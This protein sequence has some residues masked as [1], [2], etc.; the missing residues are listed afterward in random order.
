[1]KENIK[2]RQIKVMS[3]IVGLGVE[4]GSRFQYHSENSQC[5]MSVPLF[6]ELYGYRTDLPTYS[7][8]LASSLEH[9]ILIIS[10]SSFFVFF[11]KLKQDHSPVN[12]IMKAVCFSMAASSSSH[13]RGGLW[14]KLDV[15]VLVSEQICP[16]ATHIMKS[17]P[18]SL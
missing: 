7:T 9:T 16:L 4:G 8:P 1:M 3:W 11:F 18:F 14:Q 13:C 12:G 5:G 15:P 17:S 2:S 10:I 6:W